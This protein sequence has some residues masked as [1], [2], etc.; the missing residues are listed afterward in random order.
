MANGHGT[1]ITG[2]DGTG[3]VKVEVIDNGGSKFYKPGVQKAKVSE[4]IK[5]SEGSKVSC[6]WDDRAGCVVV[7]KVF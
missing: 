4:G 2:S 3:D 5:A 6:D 7:N 1:L